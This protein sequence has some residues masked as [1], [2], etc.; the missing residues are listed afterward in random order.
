MS[1]PGGTWLFDFAGQ[2]WLTWLT[3]VLGPLF[4][5]VLVAGFVG[6]RR[7]DEPWASILLSVALVAASVSVA[8]YIRW[9]ARP[10]RVVV[11]TEQVGE[12]VASVVPVMRRSLLYLA[13]PFTALLILAVW[14]FV[15]SLV[16]GGSPW[17]WVIGGVLVGMFLPQVY[18]SIA[19]RPMLALTP[20]G[21]TYRGQTIDARLG[22]DDITA[23]GCAPVRVDRS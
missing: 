23:S 22:W 6:L 16:N 2:R 19:R 17:P 4:A 13:L 3:V 8:T 14:G 18:R 9:V 11:T 5:V 20:D 10:R 15:V 21:V 1:D 12:G 7:E